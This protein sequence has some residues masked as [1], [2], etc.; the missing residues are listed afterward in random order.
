MPQYLLSVYQPV[1]DPP[2]A[3]VLEKIAGDVRE[4]RE[5]LRAAGSW[6]FS[7]GLQSPSAARG[8]R[9]RRDGMP[10]TDGP[11]IEGKEH[12]GGLTIIE[13]ATLEEALEWGRRFARATTLP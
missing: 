2:P 11:Y 9:P 3:D 10:V 1:G 7:G 6:V 12:I 8:I 4:V 5:E 13:V